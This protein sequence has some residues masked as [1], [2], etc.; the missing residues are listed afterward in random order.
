M[1]TF[2]ALAS[3]DVLDHRVR[4][5]VTPPR[6]GRPAEDGGPRDSTVS[7]I[8]PGINV[9]QKIESYRPV[10]GASGAVI[11]LVDAGTD[12]DMIAVASSA[13]PACFCAISNLAIRASEPCA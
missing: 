1:D 5:S 4:P 3:R 9:P 2:A 13:V 6:P 7:D 11:P 12:V 8:A 10:I